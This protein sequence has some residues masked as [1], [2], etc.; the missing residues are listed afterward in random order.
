MNVYGRLDVTEPCRKGH[1][2]GRYATGHCK[3]CHRVNVRTSRER[4]N[5]NERRYVARFRRCEV[6]V[7][8]GWGFS[9][10]DVALLLQCSPDTVR[11]WAA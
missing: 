10:C 2:E 11:R 1:V 7:L 6:P 8:L 9:M 4:T 5:P 3:A